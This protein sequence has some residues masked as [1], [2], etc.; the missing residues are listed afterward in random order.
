MPAADPAAGSGG[1]RGPAPAPGQQPQDRQG[2][3]GARTAAGQSGRRCLRLRPGRPLQ[4]H[5]PCRPHI[6]GYQREAWPPSGEL[7]HPM[8]QFSGR[9]SEDIWD[10]SCPL[11]STLV[12]GQR[13]E[14]EAQVI[15]ARGQWQPYPRITITPLR[16][17][18]RVRGVV[19]AFQDITERKARTPISG[20]PP[21]PSKPRKA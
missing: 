20:W 5:Q 4:F 15:R 21:W 14:G 18:G 13:R 12:D 17:E 2:R 8:F 7:R 6:L 11:R 1:Q 10:E 3:A 19:V 16:D 9:G